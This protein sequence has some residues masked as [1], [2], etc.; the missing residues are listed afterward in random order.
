MAPKWPQV[1]NGP[2]HINE[3]A[4]YLREACHQMQAVDRG[5][6]N[7]VPWQIVQSYIASTIALVGK[8]LQ[9]L[10]MS[11]ILHHIQDAAKNTQNIQRDILVFKNSV[12]LSTAPPNTANFSRDRNAAS[13]WA[14]VAVHAK[15]SP[16]IP[17]PPD[18]SAHRIPRPNPHSQHT[19]T[20]QLQSNSKTPEL[21]K[22]FGRSLLSR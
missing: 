18:H 20:E 22:D 13:T 19:K 8:V 11:E 16:P 1:N 2:E 4:T 9:Q 21:P 10:A 6:Q 7:Q 14:Q 12:G 17:P 3:H 15:G 5:K